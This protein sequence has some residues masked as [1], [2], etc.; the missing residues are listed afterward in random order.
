MLRTVVL[1][2]T[3]NPLVRGLFGSRGPVRSLA[4]R[5]V[6]GETLEDAL[7]VV[8]E[9]RSSGRLV[10]VDHL[11]ENVTTPAEARSAATDYVKVLERAPQSEGLNVAVKL[12]QLGLDLAPDLALDNT[13]AVVAAAA[14]LGA[15]VTVDMESSGYVTAILDIVRRLHV[16]HPSVGVALQASL[17]RSGKDLEELIEAGV[18]VRLC[19]G[20]Y[21]EPSHVAYPRKSQ[22]DANYAGMLEMLLAT[23]GGY[24]MVATHDPALVARAKRIVAATGRPRDSF[25][26]QMLYGVRPDLQTALAR[27]G[28]RMRV[29]VPYGSEWY[30]YLTRRMAERPA[31]LVFFLSHLRA[32]SGR[33]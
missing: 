8:D 6:A 27:Q 7:R 33:S 3:G 29:Y 32:R 4:L 18:P 2:V 15:T 13:G 12:T 28:Y 24:P 23:P 17:H 22:V 1:S 19:K 5:F 30:P 9:V 21:R 26:F 25:E 20:A 10:T 11:G 31:N 14:K 16:S